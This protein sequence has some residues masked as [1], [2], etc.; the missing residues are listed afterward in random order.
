MVVRV[1]VRV[2]SRASSRSTE[3]VVLANGGAESAKPCIVV[4]ESTAEKLGLWPPSK[5][6]VVQVEE[7]S[8]ISEAFVIDEAVELEL[9]GDRG[10]TL[11]QI[12]A[13]L[14]V[15][16]GLVE[17]LITDVTIDELGIVIVSFGRGLWRHASDPPEVLRKSARS[18]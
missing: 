12:K 15:Q 18:R 10:E 11:S 6:E 5:W 1:R 17:P 16:R 14:V 4:D 13:D 7:A 8:S 9:L 3:L 2:R